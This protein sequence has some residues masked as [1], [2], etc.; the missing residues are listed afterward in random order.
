[1]LIPPFSDVVPSQ[2]SNSDSIVMPS[3]PLYSWRLGSY[4]LA[5]LYAEKE[6]L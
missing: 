1:M 2:A 6:A 3:L 4:C 5:C